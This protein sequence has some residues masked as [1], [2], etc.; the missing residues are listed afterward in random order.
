MSKKGQ[1]I[2]GFKDDLNLLFAYSDRHD[3][4]VGSPG[5]CGL[6][7]YWM[8]LEP[9]VHEKRGMKCNIFLSAEN[10]L[11]SVE[12]GNCFYR[13]GALSAKKGCL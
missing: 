13:T 4:S 11:V 10:C 12:S 2:A 3:P 1:I 9:P 5:S 7:F 6:W 8:R